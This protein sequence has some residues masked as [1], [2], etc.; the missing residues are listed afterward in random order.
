M[1]ADLLHGFYLGDFLVEPL[2]GQVAGRAG[3]HHLPPKA[4][5]VLLCLAREPSQLVTRETLL[6]TVWGAGHGSPEALSHAVAEI[7]KSLG[8]HAGNPQFI[9][10][11][12]R[13]GYR[14]AVEPELAA[15]HSASIVI[16]AKDGAHPGDIGLFENLKRRGVLETGL[17][18]LI[19]GWLLIQIA[20]VVFAQLHLPEWVGTFVTVLV[21]AGFPIAILLSWFLEFRDGRAV[22]HQLSVADA[23][24]RRF[25]RTYMSVIGALGIAAIGV[26]VYD[27]SVGLPRAELLNSVPAALPVELPPVVE[28]SFAVLPFVN[29]DGSTETQ[30]FADGLVDD[31]TTQLSRV[32]GLRVASRG[33]AFSLAPNSASKTVRDRLR[34]EMYIEGSVEMSGDQLRVIVQMID[35]ETGF[36]ILSRRFDRPREDFFDVRDEITNL[37]VANVRVA[38]PPNI[39]ASSLKVI[40]DPSLDAYLL[41]RRGIEATRQPTSIDTIATALGWFDASLNVDPEFAAAHA[42]KCGAYVKG[43][44]KMNNSSYISSAESSC[45]AALALN[46]NLAIVHTALGELYRSTGRLDDAEFSFTAALEIDVTNV[47]ALIGL[48]RVYRMRGQFDD[49]EARLRQ[50]TGLYPGDWLAYNALGEFLYRSGRYSDAATQ[51][52]YVVALD[53][54]NAV[55]YSNLG[56]AYMLAGDFALATASFQRALDIE[57]RRETYSNLGL[58]YYY[59][60]EFS[61]AIAAHSKAVELAPND[62]LIWSNLGDAL[63]VGGRKAEAKVAFTK[64]S[65]LGQSALEVNPSDPDTLMDLAWI[66]A[67]L[68]DAVSARNLI[69]KALA[70]APD[71]PYVH[72]YDALI[73]LRAG[74]A[75]LALAALRRAAKNG[76]P[77]KTLAAEPQ[78]D[79][80]RKN[81]EFIEIINSAP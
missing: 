8:D 68:D 39:R 23:R 81:V 1:N 57:P 61:D 38:L 18:Y 47:T 64:A 48:G 2:K 45:G 13:R 14:L 27:T 69:D 40:E 49:A 35:S 63:F 19:V 73:L 42:G 34:V 78:F 67:M 66:S 36:H 26:Y 20:D 4:M 75:D 30:I 44:T 22:L 29:L 21:I 79:P 37:T 46:P 77:V 72:Y 3:S 71:E 50:A 59:R 32:P 60:G 15:E 5:E 9:Q 52:A 7:R 11:L 6:Q 43:Y 55:G 70:L 54:S 17:A 12:P 76:Y 80:L 41:Y 51:Y 31:V 58:L 53:Q 74:T 24:K 62:H 10:T 33:D 65:T 28:N 56:T 16:G 25:S